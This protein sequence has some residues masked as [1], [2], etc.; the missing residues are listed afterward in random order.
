MV[1]DID[2]D[3]QLEARGQHV[4]GVAAWDG[5]FLVVVSEPAV[6]TAGVL[7]RLGLSG[8]RRCLAEFSAVVRVEGVSAGHAVAG[9]SSWTP[10]QVTQQR[11][12][13][14]SSRERHAA[15]VAP[16]PRQAGKSAGS[17]LAIHGARAV[18][19]LTPR[20]RTRSRVL[21]LGLWGD[22]TGEP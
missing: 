20:D 19:G 21:W 6:D 10:R 7:Q 1:A 2:G 16:Q 18:V 11:R 4:I 15:G 22:Q 9:L 12:P 14:R 5:S 13:V 8:R 3:F 17:R